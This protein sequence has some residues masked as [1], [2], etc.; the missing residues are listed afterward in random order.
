MKDERAEVKEEQMEEEEEA[1]R[2]CSQLQGCRVHRKKK[3]ILQVCK[4]RQ[5]KKKKWGSEN[6]SL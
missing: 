5:K 1:G 6:V 4:L 2:C 3:N